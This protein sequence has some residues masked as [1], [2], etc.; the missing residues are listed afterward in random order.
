M[1]LRL[2][3]NRSR[4]PVPQLESASPSRA[5]FPNPLPRLA[6]KRIKAG[7]WPARPQV[8][9]DEGYIRAVAALGAVVE[10]LVKENAALDLYEV[11]FADAP[12]D[13][14]VGAPSIKTL[15]VLKDPAPLPAGA[16]TARG[17]QCIAWH[18]DGSRRVRG[19]VLRLCAFVSLSRQ[20][21]MVSG[22]HGSCRLAC[23]RQGEVHSEADAISEPGGT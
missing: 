4:N 19:R 20:V 16:R 10:E 3:G 6:G 13:A 12:P 18:P 17:A 8:E 21:C 15:T 2:H 14:A 1:R 22:K 23:A 9:K 11:Y 5:D 7:Q